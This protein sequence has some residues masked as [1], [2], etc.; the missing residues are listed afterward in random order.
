MAQRQQTD[1]SPFNR[2]R[3]IFPPTSARAWVHLATWE[4]WMGSLVAA[5][6]GFGVILIESAP[7][8]IATVYDFSNCY[9]PPP[10]ALPCARAIYTTGVLNAAFTVLCGVV[11][12]AVAVWFLWELWSAVE[13][14]PITD[15]FLKLLDQSFGRGWRNPLRW[16]W[17]RLLWAYGF[18]LVGA[19]TA[20]GI[21]LVAWM[22]LIPPER[23]M[24]VIHVETGGFSIRDF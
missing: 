7:G 6:V 1:L 3:P 11:L 21:G 15:D 12:L 10:V 9:A 17:G 14:P 22:F 16:P 23:G 24:P 2:R 18:T 20:V 4:I 13:P 8:R 19:A 5:V